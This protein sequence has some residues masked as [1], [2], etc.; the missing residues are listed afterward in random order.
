ML[1]LAVESGERDEKGESRL[2]YYTSLMVLVQK[3]VLVH[4]GDDKG[5]E[6]RKQ[7]LV[8]VKYFLYSVWINPRT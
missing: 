4:A 5:M 8:L 3:G 2:T 6:K 1:E 7:Q